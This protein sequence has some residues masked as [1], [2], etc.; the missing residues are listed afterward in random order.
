M[1]SANNSPRILSLA[2]LSSA[3]TG[4]LLWFGN[5]LNPLW[6][7][8]WIA[9]LPVLLFAARPSSRWTATALVAFLGFFCGCLSLWQYFRVL[10]LPAVAFIA[11]FSAASFGF[12]LSVLLFHALLRRG[13]AWSALLAFPAAWVSIEFLHSVLTID[14]TAG[15]LAYTQLKFLPFLQLASVTGPCGITFLL[16]LFPAAIAIALHLR[17]SDRGRMAR[18]VAASFGVIALVLIAGAIRL[19]R[20]TPGPLVTVGLIASD[21]PDN[22]GVADPGAATERRLTGY[23]AQVQLLAARGATVIVLPEHLAEVTD[24][25]TSGSA[26]STANADAI[27]Q[28]VADSTRATII[29]GLAHNAPS[30][31]HNQARIYSPAAPIASYNKRHLLPPW[32]SRFAPGASLAL[33]SRPAGT[34]G[35]AI[36]K[37]MDFAAPARSYGA[38]GIGLLLDPA[39]DF[40]LDRGWHGHIAIMRGVEDGFS[41]AHAARNGYLTVTDSRGRILAETRSDSAPFATLIAQVP[42]THVPTLYLILGNWAAWLSLIILA[43]S[44]ARLFLR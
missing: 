40:R 30:D 23:A 43:V 13:H 14:G 8:M 6:P 12:A 22:S 37:D 5:G 17:H 44:L 29:V 35:V 42:V 11:I 2:L 25:P 32:E 1:A 18:I 19:A 15:S 24:S 4:A 16:L 21:S 20:S 31:S 38:A 9:P 7:L 36:C 27:F 10:Q 26:N 3:A 33:I 41:I 28:P 34:Y 39:W